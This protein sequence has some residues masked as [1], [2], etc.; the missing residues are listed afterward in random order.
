MIDAE[1]DVSILWP[2]SSPDDAIRCGPQATQQ[3]R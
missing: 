1:T 2:G 3:Q